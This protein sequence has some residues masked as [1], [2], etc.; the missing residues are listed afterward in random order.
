MST[1]RGAGLA[2]AGPAGLPSG[3]GREV[4]QQGGQTDTTRPSLRFQL[5]ADVIV[6]PDGD[7]DAHLHDCSGFRTTAM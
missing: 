7:G 4:T 2:D 5:V 6:Q 3:V 1:D